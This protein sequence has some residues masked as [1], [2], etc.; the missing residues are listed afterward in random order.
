MRLFFNL[1]RLMGNLTIIMDMIWCCFKELSVYLF[2]KNLLRIYWV[3]N[4]V[5]FMKI[6]TIVL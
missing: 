2:D 4:F 5:F 3:F 1:V 6:C